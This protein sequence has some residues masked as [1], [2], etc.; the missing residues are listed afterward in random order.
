MD[1]GGRVEIGNTFEMCVATENGKGNWAHSL[2]SHS[3]GIVLH[4]DLRP[5]PSSRAESLSNIREAS[6]RSDALSRVFERTGIIEKGSNRVGSPCDDESSVCHG[7]SSKGAAG[8]V[9][10]NAAPTP[11]PSEQPRHSGASSRGEEK[12]G[13]EIK[14]LSDIGGGG[15]SSNGSGNGWETELLA[16]AFEK[17]LGKE[18]T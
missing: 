18:A 2:G 11:S 14:W 3:G 12:G 6:S 1:K 10:S 13:E 8:P 17:R 4:S 5:S 15:D 7:N 9:P 16:G